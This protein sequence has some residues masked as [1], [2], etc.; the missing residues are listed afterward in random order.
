M[1]ND[2]VLGTVWDCHPAPEL[3]SSVSA[4]SIELAVAGRPLEA[5]STAVWQLTNAR[6]RRRRQLFEAASGALYPV[7]TLLGSVLLAAPP[8]T[9]LKVAA[10]RE[11]SAVGPRLW[12]QR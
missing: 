8:S 6:S 7:T 9:L 5:V 3:S 2:A 12:P 1:G 11:R 4:E 10:A